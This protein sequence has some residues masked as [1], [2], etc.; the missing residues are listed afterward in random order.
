M[1]NHEK[2]RK[3]AGPACQRPTPTHG[4]VSRPARAHGRATTMWWLGHRPPP[5]ADAVSRPLPGFP[6]HPRVLLSLPYPLRCVKAK[7][8]FHLPRCS[9]PSPSLCSSHRY[10]VTARHREPPPSR[11]A[12][13]AELERATARAT[14]TPRRLAEPYRATP[15][16]PLHSSTLSIGEDPDQSSCGLLMHRYVVII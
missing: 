8:K 1:E 13:G 4:R 7:A 2:I 10:S 12:H 5:H 9:S 11:A 16:S 6:C 14:F 3:V 15:P